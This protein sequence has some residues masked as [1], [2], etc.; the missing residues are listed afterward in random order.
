MTAPPCRGC[1]RVLP[2]SPSSAAGDPRAV[3]HVTDHGGLCAGNELAGVWSEAA[4][5]DNLEHLLS[6]LEDA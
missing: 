4:R 5:R 2:A 6:D 1:G 3:A